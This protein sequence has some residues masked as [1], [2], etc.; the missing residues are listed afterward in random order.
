MKRKKRWRRRTDNSSTIFSPNVDLSLMFLVRNRWKYPKP[1]IRPAGLAVEDDWRSTHVMGWLPAQ[2][3]NHN[4]ITNDQVKVQ[5]NIDQLANMH[6]NNYFFLWRFTNTPSPFPA[7]VE[8]F[9]PDWATFLIQITKQILTSA[10][11]PV[12]DTEAVKKL[13]ARVHTTG[14]KAM[15]YNMIYA[16]SLEEG[17]PNEVKS[18]IVRNLQDHFNFGKKGD[19]TAADINNFSIRWSNWQFIIQSWPEARRNFDGWQGIPWD[20]TGWKKSVNLEGFSLSRAL[21]RTIH[22][23]RGLKKKAMTSWSSSDISTG[24]LIDWRPM[25]LHLMRR[26]GAIALP[27]TLPTKQ[28][29]LPNDG[30]DARESPIIA[31]YHRG[32][33][34]Q[35]SQPKTT[36]AFDRCQSSQQA[37]VTI[38]RLQPSILTQRC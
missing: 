28:L 31:A 37:V 4:S 9:T 14:A 34:H 5:N 20:L 29:D 1:F 3:D 23:S 25:S 30:S 35:P 32:K 16:V 8:R 26:F 33:S 21:S 2:K 36:R 15:L 38:W 6:I 27:M 17:V 18:A 22:C 13:V 24:V 11:L 19:V 7:N 12:I 10:V